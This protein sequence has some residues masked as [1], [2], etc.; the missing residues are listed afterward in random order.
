M[1]TL[2]KEQMCLFQYFCMGCAIK[3]SLYSFTETMDSKQTP[4]LL[5]DHRNVGLILKVEHPPV[6]GSD[7]FHTCNEESVVYSILLDGTQ[8]GNSSTQ[9]LP[10]G[11]KG[12]S[13]GKKNDVAA[14]FL[15]L[16]LS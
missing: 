9:A 11:K 1:V 5:E 15:V 16:S 12:C 4:V 2:T 8:L 13:K 7:G 14:E 10:K 3:L 6:L